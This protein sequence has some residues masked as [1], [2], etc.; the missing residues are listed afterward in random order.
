MDGVKTV[1]I[2]FTNRNAMSMSKSEY[3]KNINL[4]SGLSKQDEEFI[5]T[6]MGVPDKGL[7]SYTGIPDR[8]DGLSNV[9]ASSVELDLDLT[10]ANG[11]SGADLEIIMWPWERQ[12]VMVTAN[13]NQEYTVAQGENSVNTGG[14]GVYV[15]APN[16]TQFPPQGTAYTTCLNTDTNGVKG[17]TLNMPDAIYANERGRV[18]GSWVDVFY[19]GAPQ[20]ATGSALAWEYDQAYQDQLYIAGDAWES[21]TLANNT[22]SGT[23]QTSRVCK[24]IPQPI[25]SVK[26]ARALQNTVDLNV[27]GGA[28]MAGHHYHDDNEAQYPSAQ[29]KVIDPASL[30]NQGTGV[31]PG[32]T[33]GLMNTQANVRNGWYQGEL[34]YW[35]DN[36]TGGSPTNA[37]AFLPPRNIWS[38]RSMKGIRFSGLNTANTSSTGTVAAKFKIVY[39]VVYE[40]FPDSTNALTASQV[41]RSPPFNNFALETYYRLSQAMQVAYPVSW[42][43]KKL[44]MSEIQRMVGIMVNHMKAKQ[45]RPLPAAK[46]KQI[47][48]VFKGGQPKQQQKAAKKATKELKVASNNLAAAANNLQ[49]VKYRGGPQRATTK[50]RRRQK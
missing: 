1:Y 25:G 44:F 26:L 35:S 31:L 21:V 23:V 27:T 12:E 49:I 3:F 24:R 33:S 10:N 19:T 20:Y 38:Q 4:P 7:F 14:I 40:S 2:I 32:N 43:A 18:V 15:Q 22:Y 29:N 13:F 45:Y 11:G 47:K 46:A 48:S 9:R 17:Q 41:K 5:Y 28:F 50:G 36:Q 34:L 8:E 42:N 16:T 37:T 39:T 30:L 6:A